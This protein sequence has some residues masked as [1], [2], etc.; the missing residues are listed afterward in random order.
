MLV[1]IS[2]LM[3][4]SLF[5]I[6]FFLMTMIFD[7]INGVSLDNATMSLA[8]FGA[9]FGLTFISFWGAFSGI[10]HILSAKNRN[11]T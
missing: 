2:G 10:I 8:E 5:T 3:F 11:I 1:F 7:L 6:A 9:V 4:A